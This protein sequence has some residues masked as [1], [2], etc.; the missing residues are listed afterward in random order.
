MDQL[1]KEYSS[2]EIKNKTDYLCLKN[3][4]ASIATDEI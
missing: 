3:R 1:I 4:K 2:N